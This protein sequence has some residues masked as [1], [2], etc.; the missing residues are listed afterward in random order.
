MKRNKSYFIILFTME[1]IAISYRM[2]VML[3]VALGFVSINSR[4]SVFGQADNVSSGTATNFAEVYKD[5]NQTGNTTRDNMGP[6]DQAVEGLL[7]GHEDT[8]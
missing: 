2:M 5:T 4:I 7:D 3:I 1:K 8:K 6:V